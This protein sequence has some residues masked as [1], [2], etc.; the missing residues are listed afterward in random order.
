MYEEYNYTV[1]TPYIFKTFLNI[2]YDYYRQII[3]VFSR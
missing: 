2:P 1:F 3:D